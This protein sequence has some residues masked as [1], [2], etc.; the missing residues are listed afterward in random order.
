[1]DLP[2]LINGLFELFGAFVLLANVKMIRID[3]TVRGMDWRTTAFF[4]SW[5]FWNIFYYSNLDQW[6]SF[7]GGLAIAAVNLTWLGHIAYYKY[8]GDFDRHLHEGD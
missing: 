2:D 7:A 1:M 3:K 5:G 4:T 6:A 8:T